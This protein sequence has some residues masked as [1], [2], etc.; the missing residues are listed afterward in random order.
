MRKVTHETVVVVIITIIVIAT[1]VVCTVTKEYIRSGEA[2]QPL[3]VIT[4][5]TIGRPHGCE[6]QEEPWGR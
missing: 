3:V 4:V 6:G 5:D 2:E 1:R